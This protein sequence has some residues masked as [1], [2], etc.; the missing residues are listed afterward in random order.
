MRE[1]RPGEYAR[2]VDDFVLFGDCKQELQEMRSAIVG[3]LDGLRLTLHAGKSRIHRTMDGITFLGWRITPEG[4]WMKRESVV[5]M[6]RRFR[7]MHRG[8]LAGDITWE[9]IQQRVNSW[10]GN[11]QWGD[12]WKLRQQMFSQYP[13]PRREDG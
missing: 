9:E 11:A 5:R 12:T 8:W 4:T 2:Y 10:I 7:R 1:L 6:R 3:H 13:F